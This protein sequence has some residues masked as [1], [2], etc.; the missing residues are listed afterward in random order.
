LIWLRPKTTL[1]NLAQTTESNYTNHYQ[2]PY[3][4][5]IN[6]LFQLIAQALIMISTCK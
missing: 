1:P 2:N 4:V 6:S 5:S 3:N